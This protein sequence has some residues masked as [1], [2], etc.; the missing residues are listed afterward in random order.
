[1]SELIA[2][3]ESHLSRTGLIPP[4]SR[5][6]VGYSGG[7]DSTFL[8]HAMHACAVDVVAGHLHHGQR[9]EG[10]GEMRRCE[11]FAESL[12]VPFAGGRADVPKMAKELKIGLEEAG[13]KA[14]YEFFQRAAIRCRC[15]LIATAHT[16]DDH[17][18]TVLLNLVRGCGMSGLSGIPER[19]DNIV[20]PALIFTRAETRAYCETEALWFHDDPANADPAFSRTRLRLRVLP[21]LRSI[22][23]SMDDNVA[24]MAEIVGEEDRFLDAA[25]AAALERCEARLN[26]D[27]AFVSA[28]C[29][30]AFDKGLLGHLPPVLLRRALRLAFSALGGELDHAQTVCLAAGLA[31]ESRGSVTAEGGRVVAE[32]D[33]ER[34]S[35]RDLQ[36]CEPFRFS[37]AVPG[38]TSS[39]EFGWTFTVRETDPS[40][41]RR[42]RNSLS[43]VF[44]PDKAAGELHIRTV[45]DGDAI[46]PLGMTGKRKISDILS[47][48]GLTAT[49]KRRL[50]IV[51]DMAGPIWAPGL[52]MSD[53]VKIADGTQRALEL[54][55]GPQSPGELRLRAT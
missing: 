30:V 34:V 53:R 43:V 24:R 46:A 36:P 45:T 20:R 18:E 49:A 35:V 6:L 51:C 16:R 42:P 44:D 33:E 21:E 27:L 7:A 26:G 54:R 14:R 10:D 15:D 17:I 22:N 2:R 3:L 12:G 19:R 55:F 4:E 29:E 1:M 13:R 47:E 38:E 8:L 32:W 40:A 23:A 5:V 37:L 9:K 50:P 11:E 31:A 52:C 39:T 41:F 28:D 25:A 48:A